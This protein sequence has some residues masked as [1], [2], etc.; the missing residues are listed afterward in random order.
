MVSDTLSK[1]PPSP[2][3]D[4]LVDCGTCVNCQDKVK[5]GGSHTKKQKC[6]LKLFTPEKKAT[7]GE[8][9]VNHMNFNFIMYVYVRI[10]R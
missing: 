4:K 5:F 2:P 1:P 8:S 9:V 6:L 7:A 3:T 10:C